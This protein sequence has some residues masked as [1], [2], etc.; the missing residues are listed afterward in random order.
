[1]QSK[2][3]PLKLISRSISN[4]L[5]SLLSCHTFNDMFS[6][7]TRV[8]PNYFATYLPILLVMLINPILYHSASNNIEMDMA[9]GSSQVSAHLLEDGTHY[10]S[11]SFPVHAHGTNRDCDSEVE[12]PDDQRRLLRVLGPKPHLWRNPV[13]V[14]AS[15]ARETLALHVVRYGGC[16]S[17]AG[18]LQLPRLSEVAG[19]LLCSHY[20]HLSRTFTVAENLLCGQ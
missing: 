4:P 14:L 10:L 11:P 18:S 7:L 1:M 6:A 5:S 12:I 3:S 16:K 20:Y 13:D 9:S 15:T 19:E 2:R 17:S 8:L